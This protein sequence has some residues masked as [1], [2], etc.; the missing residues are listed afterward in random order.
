[1]ALL[2]LGSAL[3][4]ILPIASLQPSLYRAGASLRSFAGS[5]HH[6]EHDD[7][8]EEHGPA[9]TPTVF[10]KLITLNV[11]D[12]NGHRHTVRTLVGKTLVEALV[13][14]GFPET[15]FFPNMGFYTQHMDD[16]HV[17]IPKEFWGKIPTFEDDSDEADAI[18]RMF[19]LIV[20]D[21]AKDTSYFASYISLTHEMNGMN[22]GIGPIK[23]WIL[24]PERS[25]DGVHD[26]PVSKFSHRTNEIFG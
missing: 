15:Y 26:S 23:P 9:E 3:R 2:R 4:S 17:F 5:A 10:D 8:H 1:M 16:A 18:C 21:Y 24:H 7:H 22:V 20:Q 19:K 14:A 6:H 25:F 12:M 11:I 13:E